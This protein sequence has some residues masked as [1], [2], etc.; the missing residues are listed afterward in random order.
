VD[1]WDALGI[2]GRRWYVAVPIL[3]TFVGLAVVTSGQVD[4][5]YKAEAS[6]ILLAPNQEPIDPEAPGAGGYNPWLTACSSCETVGQALGLTLQGEA[7]KRAMAEDGW[8][9]NYVIATEKRSSIV[10]LEAT[11][12]DPAN[13]V[14][15]VDALIDRIASELETVQADANAPGDE[16]ITTDVLSQDDTASGD[17]STAGRM[18]LTL[19]AVGVVAAF[20]A[21]FA[22]EGAAY[23]LRRRRP[24]QHDTPVDGD[25]QAPSYPARPTVPVDDSRTPRVRQRETTGRVR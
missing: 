7:E 4:A 17:F 11:S 8:S 13:A 22:V 3:L 25:D 15:T 24:S 18:R 19:L 12:R 23:Y 14:G 5:E 20:A 16:R 1:I 6:V 2:L 9:T 10:H 21:A